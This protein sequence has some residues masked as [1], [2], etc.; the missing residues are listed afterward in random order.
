VPWI[1][2]AQWVKYNPP[3]CHETED[4]LMET[5]PDKVTVFRGLTQ[6]Q[7]KVASKDCGEGGL[8]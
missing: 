1:S 3:C 6:D 4:G 5:W 8:S 7:M 2:G